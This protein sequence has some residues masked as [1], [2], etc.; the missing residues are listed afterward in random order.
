MFSSEF[1][2]NNRLH[3]LQNIGDNELA[4]ITAQS[5]LQRSGDTTYPFRQDSNFFYLTGIH[6]PDVVLA[7]GGGEEFLILPKRSEAETIF[8]GEINRDEIAKISGVMTIYSHKEGWERYKKL[9]NSRKKIY[10]VGQAPPRVSGIDSFFTNP[11]RRYLLQKLKRINKL[12]ELIDIRPIL[13]TMRQIKQSEEI[14]AIQK[15]IQI[16]GD[17]F[18]KSREAYA[19]GASEYEIEALFDF[20]FKKLQVA[21]GYQPIIA[22]GARAC[23]L[24]YIKNSQQLKNEN[25]C[26][27]DVGAEYYNY[28]AD[29]TRMFMRNPSERELEVYEAVI[30]VQDYAI[31]ILK[32]GLSWKDFA[33]LVEQNMGE[34]LI[35]LKLIKSP[36]R[37]SIRKYFPHGIGHSIGLDVHDVCDYKIIKENM[38]ITVE[39][40]IYIP[41]EGIG[42]RIEDNVLITKD[43]TINLSEDVPYN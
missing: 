22:G 6:E 35:Q 2:K 23:V 5:L 36:T 10:T 39:P 28:S 20:E 8:G 42:V 32:S 26:L 38:V 43:G 15:A 3:L 12:I 25:L 16:T 40:G 14:K 27:L 9:Q 17:G 37:E 31:G 24:H 41:E 13:S 33:N 19:L 30:E 34:K 29:I 1:F 18:V 21:H 7:M 4:V 11:A